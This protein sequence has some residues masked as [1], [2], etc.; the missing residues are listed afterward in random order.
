MIQLFLPAFAPIQ[1]F[2]DSENAPLYV[3]GFGWLHSIFEAPAPDQCDAP[4]ASGDATSAA[5]PRALAA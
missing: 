5:T 2:S 4:D 3:P 1:L